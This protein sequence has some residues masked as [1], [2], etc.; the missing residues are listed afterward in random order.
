MKDVILSP[1]Q[2]ALNVN[3]DKYIYGAFSEIGAGQEVV[4]HFF[5]SGGASGTIAKAMSAYDM[6]VSDAIYGKEEDG[7]YVCKSRL[8][9]IIEREYDLLEERLDRKKHPKKLFFSFAN[10]VATTK[11]DDMQP[12]HGWVGVRFQ[13]NESE[14]PNDVII[15]IRLHENDA[16][17]QQETIGILGV[18]L[19]YACFNYNET[20][21]KFIKSLYDNLTRK[22]MEIDMVHMN[23]AKFEGIDNR[24]LS[25]LLVKNG[26]TE[27]VIFGPDGN[28]LQPSDVLYKKNILAL[29][30]S[31]RPV[32]K[33][34]IDMI[35]NGLNEFIKENK[36]QENNLQVIFEITLNNLKS[37]GDINEKDFL[38][39][40]NILCSIGQTVMI[41][42][43]QRYY[44]LLD[45]FGRFTKERLG[46]ILGLTNLQEIFDAQYYRNLDG[47]I[48]EGI[49][50][51]FNRDI[52]V[53]VY[54]YKP[55]SKSSLKT[56]K[57]I[58][59][60]P[61]IKP[62]YEF[63]L[64]NKRIIDLKD[65]K[66]DYLSIFSRKVLK[67]IKKDKTG[68]EKMVPTYVDNIIKENKLFGFGHI[69]TNKLNKET[70]K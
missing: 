15:H 9:K 53:Y 5:R 22:Q 54:P 35:K 66:E 37:E 39:R 47:G 38:D 64:F 67:M 30:G 12:G 27:A 50:K 57:N 43:Y 55:D 29:R 33:V 6:D 61:R 51:M 8:K 18:N 21:E 23:G 58:I 45:Y 62:L 40:V 31:F 59:I 68:W 26:M 41:S 52:K 28:N 7:R 48:L 25:L 4:R 69:T 36:V 10:T 1:A 3:L 60:Q 14:M 13:L 46:I 44:K 32:T 34:N 56:S 17:L 49:G 11:Y 16:K 63:F 70:K 19:L 20:P 2:K 24:L 42:N 65:Y